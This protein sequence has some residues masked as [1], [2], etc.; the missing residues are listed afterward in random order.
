MESVS[1]FTSTS[2]SLSVPTSPKSFPDEK[3]SYMETDSNSEFDSSEDDKMDQI[4]NERKDSDRFTLKKQGLQ[5]EKVGHSIEA[6]QCYTKSLELVFD[7]K[8]RYFEIFLTELEGGS[9]KIFPIG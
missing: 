7:E 2:A 8:A 3:V 4:I 5:L 6:Y 1:Q 9:S